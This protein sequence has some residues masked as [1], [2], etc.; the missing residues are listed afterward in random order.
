MY[1]EDIGGTEGGS[2]RI[3]VAVV[4]KGQKLQGLLEDICDVWR[5][6]DVW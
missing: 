6:S 4:V 1:Y 3:G 2:W 5:M